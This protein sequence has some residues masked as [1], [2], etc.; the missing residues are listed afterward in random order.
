MKFS[1]AT[2]S[3]DLVMPQASKRHLG[4]KTSLANLC[5][6]TAEASLK[7]EEKKPQFSL[8]LL[9]IVASEALP[10]WVAIRFEW[11]P[12]MAET[13]AQPAELQPVCDAG[14]SIQARCW[15]AR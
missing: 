14:Y 7:Q 6:L 5:F 10:F 2:Q 1:F 13:Q 3:F 4:W 8:T 9:Q 11:P 12:R 15:L